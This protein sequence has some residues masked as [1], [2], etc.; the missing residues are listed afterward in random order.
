MSNA[1]PNN[2]MNLAHTSMP[3]VCLSDSE[4]MKY[5]KNK[6]APLPF[7][8]SLLRKD[9]CTGKVGI[10]Y[11]KLGGQ[12]LYYPDDIINWLKNL[13]L[14]GGPRSESTKSPEESLVLH[15]KKRGK[16][17][18]AESREAAKKGITVKELRA[19]KDASRLCPPTKKLPV[20]ML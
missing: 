1:E 10:P 9:R 4:L 17:T 7:S 13:P 12:C 2:E 14:A 18:A 20:F 5:F 11:R 15:S 3:P 19:Q 6:G 8:L 16:P